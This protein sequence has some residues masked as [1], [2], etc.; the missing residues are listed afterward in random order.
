MEKKL[1]L[2]IISWKDQR[3]WEKHTQSLCVRRKSTLLAPFK[4]H[5]STSVYINSTGA[6]HVKFPRFSTLRRPL[7]VHFIHNLHSGNIFLYQYKTKLRHN[8]DFQPANADNIK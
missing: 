3:L 8:M 1:S 6:L 2:A 5:F 7:K 4:G